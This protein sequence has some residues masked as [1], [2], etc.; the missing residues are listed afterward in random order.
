MPNFHRVVLSVI[1]FSVRLIILLYGYVYNV[2]TMVLCVLGLHTPI[3]STC[4]RPSASALEKIISLK[5]RPAHLALIIAEND[6]SYPDIASVIVWCVTCGI[7]NIS[8]YDHEGVIKQHHD[9]LKKCIDLHF[10]PEVLVEQL[11]S[12]SYIITKNGRK[13]G[14]SNR[15]GKTVQIHLLSSQDGRPDI[16]FGARKLVDGVKNKLSAVEDITTHVLEGTLKGNQSLPCPDL[17]ICFGPTLSTIGF[18]PWHIYLTEILKVST[19]H[20]ITYET[21]HHLLMRF[22]K[23]D[24]RF[25]K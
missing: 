17:A 24:Q 5:R 15:Y 19:H 16:V 23:C 11:N 22:G 4:S 21:F 25:G 18:L 9:T 6:I 14:L 1:H 7:Y 3:S 2:K 13:N 20:Q 8:I 10:K 12:S